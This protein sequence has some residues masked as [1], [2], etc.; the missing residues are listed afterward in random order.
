VAALNRSVIA[1]Y[2]N[3]NTVTSRQ[4][5]HESNTEAP[6]RPSLTWKSKKN[7]YEY[8][9]V[10]L[11]SL[12][13]MQIA[14]FLRSTVSSCLSLLKFPTLSHKRN[15]FRKNVI[16]QKMNVLIF[17]ATTVEKVLILRKI[18]R[19]IIINVHRVYVKYPLFCHVLNKFKFSRQILGKTNH[20]IRV[21][22]VIKT[23]SVG[24]TL[25]QVEQ[26]DKR[27]DR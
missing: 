9:S 2:F 22:N 27:T 18:Q 12:S 24:S 1:V 10:F 4:S 11:S 3:C 14:Y 26:T 7:Y 19:H 5:K 21:P 17:Y 6:T 15:D 8:V 25:F 20:N 16:E 23:R 13:G